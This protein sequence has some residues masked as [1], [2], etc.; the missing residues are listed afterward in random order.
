MKAI[1]S[2]A[3]GL[4]VVGHHVQGNPRY[5][6]VTA[7]AMTPDGT[8]ERIM[9]RPQTKCTLRD[10]IPLMNAALEKFEQEMGVA[11]VDAGFMAVAR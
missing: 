2:M 4:E 9:V 7:W 10:I 3:K 5:W 8:K 11:T 1:W 6:T